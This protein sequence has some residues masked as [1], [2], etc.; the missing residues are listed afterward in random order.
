MTKRIQDDER[1]L[2]E[3]TTAKVCGFSFSFGG[4]LTPENL[5]RFF[6]CTSKH[7]PRQNIRNGREIA[8]VYVIRRLSRVKISHRPASKSIIGLWRPLLLLIGGKSVWQPGNPQSFPEMSGKPANSGETL[9]ECFGRSFLAGIA[10]KCTVSYLRVRIF[11]FVQF[12]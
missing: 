1:R 7:G 12:K 8:L 5:R 11:K 4:S 6:F 9:C 3:Q 2:L 10:R